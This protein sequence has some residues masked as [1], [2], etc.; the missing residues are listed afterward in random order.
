M[1]ARVAVAAA[2]AMRDL[3]VIF[4]P[5][6]LFLFPVVAAPMTVPFRVRTRITRHPPILFPPEMIFLK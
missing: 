6:Y 4:Y 1:L 2:K 5:R 3:K